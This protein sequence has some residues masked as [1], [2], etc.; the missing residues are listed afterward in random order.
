MNT[1][2]Y[3]LI[4]VWHVNRK[5]WNFQKHEWEIIFCPVPRILEGVLCT[6]INSILWCQVT[7]NIEVFDRH[8]IRVNLKHQLTLK[9]H[10]QG[11]LQV[12]MMQI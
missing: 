11:F 4:K 1:N 12:S 3:K 6:I 7:V 10:S 9:N 8:E 2:S 5:P